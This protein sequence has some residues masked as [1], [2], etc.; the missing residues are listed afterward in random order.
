M[1]ANAAN[2]HTFEVTTPTEREIRM[3]RI[4]NAPRKLVFEVMT[5]PE[6]VKRWW[7]CLGEGYSVPFCEIDLRVGGA[8]RYVGR[9]PKG[10][11]A[12]Y[13]V[14]REIVAPERLVNTEIFEPFP[15]AESVV[16]TVLTEVNGKT[17]MALTAT[18]PS[19]EVRDTVVASGMEKGAAISYD[20]LEDLVV[21]LMRS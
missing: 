15:D 12:F 13:G 4:F 20:R 2:S 8:W 6:H 17:H 10:E 11:Y 9:S 14:Y 21:E 18:Y 5:E 3:T 1:I 7:G 16:T 19:V